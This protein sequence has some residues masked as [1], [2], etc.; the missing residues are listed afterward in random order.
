MNQPP[1]LVLFKQGKSNIM[2]LDGCLCKKMGS[3]GDIHEIATAV[4]AQMRHDESKLIR[5][6]RQL[7]KHDCSLACLVFSTDIEGWTPIHACA[8]RG[9]RRLLKLMLRA[10]VDINIRMG[11]PSGLPAHC[12]L[13]HIAA[14]RGDQKI[15]ELLVSRGISLNAK[16]S[17]GRTAIR[18]A[19]EA[20]HTHIVRYLTRKGA[21]TTNVVIKDVFKVDCMTPQPKLTKF[22]F[23]PVKC[24]T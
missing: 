16:D 12:S 1:G 23:L 19:S 3:R 14:H 10:K 13:L 18:Y 22:C 15:T 5:Q 24:T 2:T 6:L 4:M 11:H 17:T 7:I 20:C 8:L 9:S 21:D